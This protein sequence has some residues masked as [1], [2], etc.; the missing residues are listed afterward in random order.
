MLE[1]RAAEK[2]GAKVPLNIRDID[3]GRVVVSCALRPP[4]FRKLN[5]CAHFKF[6]GGFRMN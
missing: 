4:L 5:Y 2:C 3:T 6:A 1:D